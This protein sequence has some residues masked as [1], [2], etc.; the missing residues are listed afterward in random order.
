MAS[1]YQGSCGGHKALYSENSC[2]NSVELNFKKMLSLNDDIG[3]KLMRIIGR[4]L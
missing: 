3:M 2:V 1:L 4:Y